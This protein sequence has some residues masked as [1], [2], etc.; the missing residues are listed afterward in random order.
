MPKLK[1]HILLRIKEMLRHEALA[2]RENLNPPQAGLLAIQGVGEDRDFMYFKSDCMYQHCLARF[3]YTTYD[4]RRS[5][6]VIN[7]GTPH[8]DIMLLASRADNG[9]APIHP[10][11]YARVLGIYHVNVIYT[12]QGSL[13]NAPRRMEF[14]WVRW[15]EYDG[16]RSVEWADLTL[17]TIR[18]LPMADERAFGFVDPKSVL[19][20]C[21]IV[22]AFARGGARVDG[23]GLSR[24]AQDAQDWV[25]YRVNRCVQFCLP[26]II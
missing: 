6:D 1:D 25:R 2:S 4:I 8:R 7:P 18:F 15:F 17:N 10:F 21:H 3:N 12:G 24:L 23:I 13:D 26:P 14:L 5:Q 19:R 16:G 22:P 20:S 9:E 11:L